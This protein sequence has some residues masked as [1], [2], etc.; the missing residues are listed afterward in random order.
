[1]KDKTY[2][3]NTVLTIVLGAAAL[4]AALVRAFAPIVIIPALNVPNMVLV[5][6]AALL[7]DHY[8]APNAKRCY[9]CIPVL[10]ALSFGLIPWAAAFVSG[11]EAVKLAVVGG[12]VF[13]ATTWLYSSIQDRLSTGPAAKAAPF[14]SALG[15]WLAAQ[16]MV[17]IIL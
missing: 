13:T 5:S 10:G 14:M 6:L 12:V 2:I 16:A 3:L 11:M 1:M 7:L 4:T 17:G 15:L 8:L 9:I